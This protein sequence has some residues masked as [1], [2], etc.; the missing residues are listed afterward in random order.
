M[1]NK[2]FSQLRSHFLWA[3]LTALPVNSL[4]DQLNKAKESFQTLYGDH[5]DA[6]MLL[7]KDGFLS[8]N[9]T[10]LNLLGCIDLECFHTLHPCDLSPEKQPCGSNSEQLFNHHIDTALLKGNLKFEWQFH[11]CCD[12][13]KLFLTEI[14]FSTIHI[15]VNTILHA[16]I[17]DIS[18][19][20]SINERLRR[21]EVALASV[22]DGI[23]DWNIST[24]HSIYSPRWK[25]M[26]GYLDND[27]LPTNLEW[28]TRIHSD[29]QESVAEAMQAYLTGEASIYRVEY[30]LKCKDD[31]YKWILGRGMV[32]SRDQHN[33]PLRMVGTHTDI[34]QIKEAEFLLQQAMKTAQQDIQKAKS[35]LEILSMA[36]EQSHSSV[37]ISDLDANITYVNQ[38]FVNRT[39]FSRDEI[40]GQKSSLL[41]SNKT[42]PS[43]FDEMW[44]NLNNG[45]AWQGEIINLDKHGKELNELAWVSPIRESDGTISHYLSVKEDI[46]ERKKTEAIL[47]KLS[48]ALEQ[49]L[50]SVMITDLN[51]NI[52]YINQAFVNSTGYSREE[53][54]GQK[55][56]LLKSGKTSRSTYD[57]LWASLL[58]GNA[59]QGEVINV[60]KQG[61]EFIE[62]TWI[63]PIRQN[64]GTITHYLGVKEDITERKKKDA[65]LIA[66]KEK[67]EKLAK[68]KSQFLANM[69][70]EIRTPMNAI[71]GFSE[72][73]LFDEIPTETRTYLQDINVAANHLLTI[74]ND[75]LDL[76]KLEAGRM[77][78]IPA[79]FHL[80]DLMTSLHNLFFIAAQAKGLGLSF[81]IDNNI[82]DK[83]IGDS[84]RLRQV[85]INLLG[86]AIK[87]TKQ[88]S[89]TLS[90]SLQQL[91]TTEARLLFSVVD[92]GIGISAEQ[93][94]KLFKP[95]SQAEDGFSRSYE[96]TGLGLVISQ[97][98]MQLMDTSI[99]LVSNLNLGSCFS[100]E[101]ALPLVD[102]ST[103][104][105]HISTATSIN[106]EL[107]SNA[108]ILV[109]EDDEFNQKIINII[110]K[111]YGARI[112]LANNGLEALAA[113]EQDRFDIVLM[114]L[115]MPS[116][117]G[118][119]A[120]TAIRK[121][122]RYAQL[123]VIAFTAS[124]T[125]EDKQRCI[126]IG[127]ND[128]IGKP[129]NKNDL[130]DTLAQ[131][132]NGTKNCQSNFELI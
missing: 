113:L 34:T 48:M 65:L 7:N 8:G 21:S 22:G 14:V 127:M 51:A 106:P 109:V 41:R 27:I 33:K 117:N 102:I 56:S 29:D 23:W 72:L 104:E 50:S 121:I 31:S 36:L 129:L 131:W 47:T 66:A 15:G 6:V 118:Y 30:R 17:V 83:L 38:T 71:I 132:I 86:N 123:P 62:L 122:P 18:L 53:L 120:T 85:L 43:T 125:D 1:I 103:F 12:K 77:N 42:S 110:L 28:Q 92:T 16:T 70:H 40:I 84:V 44:T 73:A 97:E 45:K 94:E 52:E 58:A 130:L 79:P 105:P 124:V 128:F 26:L 59:W 69:S 111:R 87:F 101:L 116:M 19:H 74:L 78:I 2:L 37:K 115:H 112:V 11:L 99:S 93:Q 80:N 68:T 126:E 96:G 75:I 76:S 100:F 5:Q 64:D 114:D 46:T 95:F 57:E 98:L 25:E 9:Q 90:I 88:G 82:P 81:N 4:D 39:G 3:R 60:N 10:T 13:A 63:S 108:H 32:V 54:I 89:V 119:E 49:S 61:E 35:Q 91:T 20:K 107:L 55:P 24:D 67:A